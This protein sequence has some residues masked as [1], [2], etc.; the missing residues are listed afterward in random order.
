MHDDLAIDYSLLTLLLL[1]IVVR[2]CGPTTG[3]RATCGPRIKFFRPVSFLCNI[4]YV[5]Q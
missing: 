5:L 1:R 4:A 2:Q 3:L